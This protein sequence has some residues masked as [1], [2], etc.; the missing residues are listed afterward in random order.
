MVREGVGIRI[1]N[2]NDDC[3]NEEVC[4]DDDD[5]DE[6]FLDN[7][8]GGNGDGE[9]GSSSLDPDPGDKKPIPKRKFINPIIKNNAISFN[10]DFYLNKERFRGKSTILLENFKTF[11]AYLIKYKVTNDWKWKI[12]EFAKLFIRDSILNKDVKFKIIYDWVPALADRYSAPAINPAIVYKGIIKNKNK[13]KVK[14]I[15]LPSIEKD[16]NEVL[17]RVSTCFSTLP[18]KDPNNG[19]RSN[20]C[21]SIK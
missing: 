17:F 12:E 13:G 10:K 3:Y 5:C 21:C 15:V 1:E 7:K 11:D 14:K 9:G 2:Y 8:E 6:T 18:P 4:N 19:K 20:S 16:V